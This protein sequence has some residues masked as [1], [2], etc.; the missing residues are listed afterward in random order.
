ME[1]FLGNFPIHDSY[2]FQCIMDI[3]V[4]GTDG[5]NDQYVAGMNQWERFPNVISEDGGNATLLLFNQGS[6]NN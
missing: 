5:F 6:K 3:C 4:C 2:F 1:E